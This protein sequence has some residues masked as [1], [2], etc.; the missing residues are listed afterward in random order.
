MT[1]GRSKFFL[2]QGHDVES[3]T[4]DTYWQLNP[5]LNDVI[6]RTKRYMASQFDE[7]TLLYY[8]AAV[9]L[10]RGPPGI[11][12]GLAPK[13]PISQDYANHIAK[14]LPA[15]KTHGLDRAA[16]HLDAWIRDELPLQPL[17]K[18]WACLGDSKL[19]CTLPLGCRP[20][21]GSIHCYYWDG[22]SLI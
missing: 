13:N 9:A 3:K 19:C 12:A 18:V 20:F 4:E 8:P 11:P 1:E 17:L 5:D 10:V 7:R 21:N 15:L 14:F 22:F 6:L 16:S 2:C